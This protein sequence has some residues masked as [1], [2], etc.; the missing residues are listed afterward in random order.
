MALSCSL[1]HTETELGANEGEAAGRYLQLPTDDGG[2]FL[3]RCIGWSSPSNGV[4]FFR[5]LLCYWVVGRPYQG[6]APQ[7]HHGHTKRHS[8]KFTSAT[9]TLLGNLTVRRTHSSLLFSPFFL[10]FC[11]VVLSLTWASCLIS[12]SL[13]TPSCVF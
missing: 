13:P 3:C 2:I 9:W 4:F 11:P 1:R 5:F 12:L 6:F 7:T 10:L 8:S